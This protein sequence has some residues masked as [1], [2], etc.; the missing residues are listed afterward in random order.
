[1]NPRRFFWYA[2]FLV[3]ALAAL[4]GAAWVLST[5]ELEVVR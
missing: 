2:L 5:L 1:M 3:L 4:A